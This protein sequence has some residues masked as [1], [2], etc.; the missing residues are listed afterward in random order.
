MTVINEGVIFS[1]FAAA[2]GN[3]VGKIRTQ[4]IFYLL[5]Q[6]GMKS[7]FQFSYHHFG[8]YSEQLSSQLSV[9]L[10]FDESFVEE[11]K[12][13]GFGGE[14]S[15]LSF[16]DSDRFTKTSV[17]ALSFEEAQHAVSKMKSFSSKDIE[18]AATI[19]WLKNFEGLDSWE[20]ELKRRKTS[21]ASPTI[22]QNAQN[23]LSDLGLS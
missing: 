21:K 19:H 10:A 14:F 4:K 11:K 9:L 2:S 23:L 6:M 15:V 3:I 13:N 18:I 5:E 17:G 22:V 8:P 1:V 20:T 16:L 7:G 12:P